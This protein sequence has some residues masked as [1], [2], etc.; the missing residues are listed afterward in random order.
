MMVI[1]HSQAE[2]EMEEAYDYLEAQRPGLGDAFSE[3]L[4]SAFRE[5]AQAPDRWAEIEPGFRRFR[6]R[7]FQYGLIYRITNGVVE[8]LAVAHLARR[9]GYW[10]SRLS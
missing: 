2:T 6:L 10:H 9:P 8:V 7:R 5:L 1:L 4:E 3:E